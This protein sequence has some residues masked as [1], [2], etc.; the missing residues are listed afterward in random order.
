LSILRGW[1]QGLVLIRQVL[2]T[3]ATP[4]RPFC[5]CYFSDRGSLLCLYQPGPRS[6]CLYFLQSWNDRHMTN[7]RVPSFFTGW[8]VVLWN[9]CLSPPPEAVLNPVFSCKHKH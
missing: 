7:M 8:I 5:F 4:P 6:S 1:T 9:F 2:T 3:W